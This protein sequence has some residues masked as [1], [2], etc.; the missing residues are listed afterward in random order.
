MIPAKTEPIRSPVPLRRFRYDA[1]HDILKG[2]RGKILHL[3][4][5]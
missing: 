1:K 3:S 5:P 2:L 4:D